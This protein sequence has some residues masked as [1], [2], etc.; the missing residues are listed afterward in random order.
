MREYDPLGQFGVVAKG[1]SADADFVGGVIGELDA[2]GLEGEGLACDLG[3]GGA[4][5]LDGAHEER[6][7]S[8]HFRLYQTSGNI[9]Y[10]LVREN[11]WGIG[12]GKELQ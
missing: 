4:V 3:C 9:L 5:G 1:E 12:Y 6:V 10:C 11:I 7:S 2:G 8:L